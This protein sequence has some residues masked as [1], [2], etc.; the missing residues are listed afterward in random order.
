MATVS[1][2]SLQTVVTNYKVHTKQISELHQQTQ[3]CLNEIQ[4]LIN[5]EDQNPFHLQNL[6]QFD[7][8]ERLPCVLFIGSQNS[9]KSRLLNVFLERANLLPVHQTPCT[10]RIVRV[11]HSDSNYARVIDTD[12]NELDKKEFRKNVPKKFVVLKDGQREEASRLQCVVEVGLNHPLLESGIEFIDSPG[13]NE[14]AALNH[15]VEEFVKKGVVPLIVY[16]IDGNFHIRQK[17]R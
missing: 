13:R 3:E 8:A 14:N 15:V 5:V 6:P 9:G 12:G 1:I 7:F 17:V 11:L 2:Q 10:S 16:V 4:D